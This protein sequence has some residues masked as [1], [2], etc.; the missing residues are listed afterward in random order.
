MTSFT[1]F[2]LKFQHVPVRNT[3]FSPYRWNLR[4][5]LEQYRLKNLLPRS[6]LDCVERRLWTCACIF[7]R[8]FLSCPWI[9]ESTRSTFS[10]KSGEKSNKGPPCHRS[11]CSAPTAVILW[12]WPSFVVAMIWRKNLD[13]TWNVLI[14]R[15]IFD[16]KMFIKLNLPWLLFA[17]DAEPRLWRSWGDSMRFFLKKCCFFVKLACS[18]P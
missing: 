12:N 6:P 1:N 11:R 5:F 14:G 13:L 4:W 9:F 15:K 3:Y 7:L 8:F 16:V 17:V 2:N 10:R 18:L